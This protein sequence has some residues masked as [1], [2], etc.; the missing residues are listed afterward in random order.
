MP[1]MLDGT[2]T[3]LVTRTKWVRA[4]PPALDEDDD[5]GAGRPGGRPQP[6]DQAGST[7]A[8]VSWGVSR[9]SSGESGEGHETEHSGPFGKNWGRSLGSGTASAE[10]RTWAISGVS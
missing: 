6:D 7:P 5:A 1:A 9:Q 10:Q 4:P 3:A 2:G 8:G